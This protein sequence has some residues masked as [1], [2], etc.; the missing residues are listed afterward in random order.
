MAKFRMG[1]ASGPGTG[2]EVPFANT[3]YLNR[4]TGRF[5]KMVNGRATLYTNATPTGAAGGVYGWA[6]CPKDDSGKNGH[7][8]STDEKGFVYTGVENKFWMPLDT[9]SASANA[10]VVGALCNIKTANAT[11]ALTQKA[12][13]VGNEASAMLL[14]HDYDTDN[15]AVLVSIKPSAYVA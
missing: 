9:A 11:Y 1:W 6:H 5:V 7:K 2:M 12:Y 14:V 8:T 13:K 3:Q 4:Q 10:T 15:D